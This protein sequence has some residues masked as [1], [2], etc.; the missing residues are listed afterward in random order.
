LHAQANELSICFTLLAGKTEA[1]AVLHRGSMNKHSEAWTAWAL[2]KPLR[3]I[4]RT[5]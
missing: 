3:A 5:S 4:C 2:I 1:D